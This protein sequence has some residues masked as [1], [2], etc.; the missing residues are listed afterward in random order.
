[1]A[2]VA[3]ML[4]ASFNAGVTGIEWLLLDDFMRMDTQRVQLVGFFSAS[5]V[6]GVGTAQGRRFSVG[7]F[8]ALL[9]EFGG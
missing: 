8:N 3:G 9:K 5:F 6:L 2:D 7:V 1:M 4:V